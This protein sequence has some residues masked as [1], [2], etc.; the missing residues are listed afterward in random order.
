MTNHTKN[1][2]ETVNEADTADQISRRSFLRKAS[3]AGIAA[4]GAILG[5]S[6]EAAAQERASKTQNPPGGSRALDLEQQIILRAS[7]DVAY[8]KRLLANPT[9]VI[10]AEAGKVM[11]QDAKIVVVEESAKT[12][13]LVLPFVGEAGPGKL[14]SKDLEIAAAKPGLSWFRHCNTNFRGCTRIVCGGGGQGI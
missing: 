1:I 10:R 2:V 5:M 14:S 7:T 4:T 12:I 8:R 13:Y 9:A 6:E 3:V 11:P